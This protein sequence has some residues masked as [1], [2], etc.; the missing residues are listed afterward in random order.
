[1]AEQPSSF[2]VAA[3]AGVTLTKWTRAWEERRADA[4]LVVTR[5]SADDQAAVLRDSRADVSFVRLPVDDAGLSVIPLY[6]EIPVVVAP[7]GHAIEST[8]Q[9]TLADLSG[10][11]MLSGDPA[12]AI[13]LVAA[14]VGVIV[15]PQSIARLHARKDVI[16]R[17]VTDAPDTG[18]A[19]AWLANE[20]TERVE[21]FIGIVRGRTARSSRAT[22][23][24][25]TPKP[26]RAPKAG[27]AGKAGKAAT[28]RP[29][30]RPGARPKKSR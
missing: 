21:E 18:I 6:R 8:E 14:G 24:P 15:V 4:P 2:T 1:M 9:V 26:T 19:L 17:P 12:D 22:P 23:T 30:R 27:K 5:V 7:K 11:T 10:E 28:G 20:T 16:A 3:V 29:A 25:P 13:D